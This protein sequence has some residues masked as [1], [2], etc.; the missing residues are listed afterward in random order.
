M[1][2]KRELEPFGDQ[3]RE[4]ADRLLCATKHH[5]S[6]RQLVARHKKRMAWRRMRRVSLAASLMTIVLCVAGYR[7]L[8]PDVRNANDDQGKVSRDVASSN[9]TGSRGATVDDGV[10]VELAK[11]RAVVA[12]LE[13]AI[14]Q[15]VRPQVV[16]VVFTNSTDIEQAEVI[17]TGV[18]FPAQ[19]EQIELRELTSAEQRAI[20]RVLG[21]ND[22]TP[23][24]NSL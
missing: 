21:I 16:P 3:L 11:P 1:N 10:P 18:Y 13:T 12:P 14:G 2:E 20:R 19:V 22:E 23:N 7:S 5:G 17:A 15:P 4:E 8:R 9:E 6:A 24:K